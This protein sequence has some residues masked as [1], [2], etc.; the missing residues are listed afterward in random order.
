MLFHCWCNLWA[1]ITRFS[2]KRFYTDW[3]NA[4]N[5]SEY[6]RKWNHPV[7]NWLA[8][9]CYFP[10]VRRGISGNMARLLTFT[11]SAAFH[12]YVVIGA[13]RVINGVAFWGMMVNVPIMAF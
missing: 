4:G 1:E 12:E 9:H 2:D 13:L 11:V 7:H 6:W 10:M 3:W 8:R 5:L